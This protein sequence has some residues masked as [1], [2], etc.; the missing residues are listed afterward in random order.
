MEEH[1]GCAQV[2]GELGGRTT[3]GRSFKG[4]QAAWKKSLTVTPGQK[5]QGNY[6]RDELNFFL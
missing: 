1:D 2:P 4:P 5:R 6:H 3:R